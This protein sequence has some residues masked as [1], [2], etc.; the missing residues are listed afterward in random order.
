MFTSDTAGN[1]TVSAAEILRFLRKQGYEIF[2]DLWAENSLYFGNRGKE[3]LDTDRMFGSKKF[4]LTT[5]LSVLDASAKKILEA[6]IDVENFN[7]KSF[8]SKASD[9][10]AIEENLAEKMRRRWGVVKAT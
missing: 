7:Q 8:L 2:T 3:I 6:P 1:E 10:I 5:D 4:K 9:I